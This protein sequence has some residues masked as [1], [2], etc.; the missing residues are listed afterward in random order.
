M[1]L[2]RTIIPTDKDPGAVE[3]GVAYY[4]DNVASKSLVKQ[5]NYKK[6]IQYIDEFSKRKFGKE[7][8]QLESKNQL[9]ILEDFEKAL[10]ILYRKSPYLPSQKWRNRIFVR[11]KRLDYRMNLLLGGVNAEGAR[12]FRT[13]KWEMFDAFYSNPISWKMIGY[14]GP[15]QFSGYPDYGKCKNN[16]KG[17]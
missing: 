6:G 16:E 1:A 7:F 5:K 10:Q 3:A 17:V 14:Q 11:K 8:L 13:L 12:F 9:E 4:I 15:P 2:A